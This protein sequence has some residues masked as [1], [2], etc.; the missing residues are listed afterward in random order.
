[1]K[2]MA[3]FFIA[4]CM[5]TALISAPV[6]ASEAI[7]P[8]T[9]DDLSQAGVTSSNPG[10]CWHYS[11]WIPVCSAESCDTSGKPLAAE[12][13]LE[14]EVQTAPAGVPFKTM[15]ISGDALFA[16]GESALNAESKGL[17]DELARQLNSASY[18]SVSVTGHADRLGS[19]IF[20]QKLAE[21]RAS[22]VKEYLVSKDVVAGLIKAEGKGHSQPITRSGECIGAKSAKLVA[23]LQ[24]DRRVEVEMQGVEKLTSSR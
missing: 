14:E 7:T 2:S 6:L 3:K 8:A 13:A 22:S 16:F 12:S 9:L 15:S 18:D 17:L 23:C 20:N 19:R 11:D 24:P 10:Q 5:V 1:M 4:T 21:R